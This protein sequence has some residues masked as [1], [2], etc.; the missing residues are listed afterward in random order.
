MNGFRF[1]IVGVLFGSALIAGFITYVVTMR[2]RSHPK[3]VVDRAREMGS[4]EAA[5]AGREFFSEKVVPEMKPVLMDLV[6]EAEAYVDRY[7]DRAH[8]AIKAM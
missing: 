5:R 7:F 1:P 4:A 8:K 6:K 2:Q 3:T